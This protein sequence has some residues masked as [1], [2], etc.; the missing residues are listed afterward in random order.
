MQVDHHNFIHQG[1]ESSPATKI[2]GEEPPLQQAVM[3]SDYGLGPQARNS[4]TLLASFPFLDL[5]AIQSP[6]NRFHQLR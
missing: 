4:L 2:I 5:L 3:S 1:Q 6:S